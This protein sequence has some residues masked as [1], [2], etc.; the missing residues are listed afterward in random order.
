MHLSECVFSRKNHGKSFHLQRH[1]GDPQPEAEVPPHRLVILLVDLLYIFGLL[2]V[3]FLECDW[4]CVFD[5]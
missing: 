3:C 5:M 1:R 2:I 4:V